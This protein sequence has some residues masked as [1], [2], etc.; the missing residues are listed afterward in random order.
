[1]IPVA[2]V[3]GVTSALV[4]PR[5]GAIAGTSGLIHLDG[6]TWE[7]MTVQAPVG[8]HVQWPDMGITRGRW[9]ETRSPED[10][11][12]ARDQAIDAIRK[13]FDDARAYWK[14]RDAER[15]PGIPRHDRDARWDAMGRALRGEIPV[16]FHAN[17][18]NQIRAVLAFADEQALKRLVLVGGA[19][20]WRVADEL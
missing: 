2:R 15:A 19:D 1:L 11:Q 3:N 17:A 13:A 16:Y 5:G 10:Q 12:K 4:V 14:A 6:W 20:A 18:L 8:L 9:W 7:D